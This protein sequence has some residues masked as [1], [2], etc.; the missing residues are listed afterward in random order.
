MSIILPIYFII[1]AI[2]ASSLMWAFDSNGAN[3][4]WSLIV[5]HTHLDLDSKISFFSQQESS[6]LGN[7]EI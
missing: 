1:I 5:N 4:K 6:D 2:C 7:A 3:Q